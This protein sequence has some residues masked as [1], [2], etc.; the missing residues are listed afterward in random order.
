MS[1]KKLRGFFEHAY[2]LA[3]C[4]FLLWDIAYMTEAQWTFDVRGAFPAAWCLLAAAGLALSRFRLGAGWLAAALLAW[5]GAVSAYRGVQDAQAG[6][7]AHGVLAF[8]VVLPAPRAVG[9]DRLGRY[10]RGLLAVWTAF[11]TAQAA[12]GLWAALTGH[13]VFSL[14]G[15]WYIGVN[16]GDNRLYLNA[17][18]TTGAVKLGLSALMA[19]LGA[20][21]S[22]KGT[23]RALYALCAAVQLLCLSLTD[24][25]TAFLAVGAGL[26]LMTMALL[27]HRGG[28]SRR[29]L[30]CALIAVPLL[31]VGT[32]VL[33]T[34][35]LSALAP[36]VAHEL[37][38]LT[39]LELPAQLL[40]AASAEEAVQHRALAADNLFNDRQVIWG[41]A[42][43]LLGSEKRFLLTGTTMTLSP[44][45]TNAYIL[46]G[47][48]AGR[49]FA[50]VHS[51]YLQTLVAWGLPGFLL[52]LAF[53]MIFLL[54]A[55]RVLMK[56]QLP[57]WQRL[58]PVPAL[59]VM[60]CETVDCFTRLS[61]GS[62]MLLYGC[63]FAGLT[64]VIDGRARLAAHAAAS[65]RG[66]V[67]VVVPVYNAAGYVARAAQ[68]ALDAGAARVI[69]VDD[70]S[71]DGSG[72]ICDAL[73]AS[74]GRVT[75][76]HQMNRG[77]SA[78]RNAGLDAAAAAYVAFLD[79]DDELLPGALAALTGCIGDA[80]AIQGRIVRKAPETIPPADVRRLSAR[81][82]LDEA[83]RDPT[84][85]LLCHGWLFRRTLLTERFDERL[86]MGEDGEW[87][88]R[89]LQRA[90]T[91]A[92]CDV[93][94]YR[95]TV[96]ADSA[97]H[98]GGGDVNGAYL[99]AL[100]AAEPALEAL[101]MPASAALYRLTHLLLI[102]THG[103]VE[104]ALPLRDAPL[105]DAAFSSAR[106]TGLSPR[107]LTL[108]L[109]KRRAFRLVRIAVRV[110]RWMNRLAC[111]LD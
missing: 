28:R 72:D 70:G 44:A 23:P 51:I 105:F 13:A 94:A 87:L 1:A 45:L 46:P 33:L 102:L 20:A 56:H 54:A 81:D 78:A 75:V 103:D 2:M 74:D 47:A 106:L 86:T 37:D 30:A 52:L 93:P 91:A 104:A 29:R 32:Y 12:L 42:L 90:A 49:P 39:L 110:R 98:G 73:A 61:E 35:A 22:R 111:R 100:V 16:L 68:S 11:L 26:G 50:H 66:A 19:L 48:Y 107:M 71:T 95:Y 80:D 36:H 15:T 14:K 17:Y 62:P 8:L 101:E 89:T 41:A 79:A 69:L 109:L 9:F 31:T 77:A 108:R 3:V 76:L 84:R 63:L 10:L 65:V 7:L 67:D 83:L 64:L 27:L 55:R 5:M 38:N 59:Y 58:V 60:I 96:R 92:F 88:L 6:A 97:L 25:R 24:C 43:R 99:R 53:M 57:L 21:I 85:R 34:G 82:A 18:V 40:P 4:A